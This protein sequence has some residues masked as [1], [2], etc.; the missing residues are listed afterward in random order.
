M[1]RNLNQA[2]ATT[3][4]E[5]IDAGPPLL[6]GVTGGRGDGKTTLL[7]GLL[8]FLRRDGRPADGV[9]AEAEG[10]PGHGLGAERYVLRWPLLGEEAPLCER[11]GKGDPPYRFFDETWDKVGRWAE[12]LTR[13][14]T[15]PEVIVLDEF[16]R[17]EARGEGFVRHWRAI[18]RAQPAVVV[19]ALREGA[20]VEIARHLNQPFDLIV[21]ANEPQ[22]LE[23]LCELCAAARDW[24]LVGRF[25]AASGG[26]E[27]TLGAIL[28]GTKM[29]FRGVVMAA[30]QA[31]T[32]FLAGEKLA[33][34]RR[35]VWVSYLAAALKAL[36]P[37]GNR[38]RPMTAIAMQGTLF[39]SSV[40]LFGWNVAGITMG[41]WLVGAW[42][43]L[44]GYVLQYLLLGDSLLVAYGEVQGWIHRIIGLTIPSLP[45]LVA[46][47]VAVAGTASAVLVTWVRR[48]RRPPALLARALLRA[49]VTEASPVT[50]TWWQRLLREYQ[51][52]A[53]WFPLITVILLLAVSGTPWGRLAG[54]PLRAAGM[55]A[56][57]FV[58]LALLKPGTWTKHLQRRGHWGPAIALARA[59]A[60]MVPSRS[61][62]KDIPPAISETN[63]RE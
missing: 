42:A 54:L 43:A 15:R 26:V 56:F 41:A 14:S 3:A 28:H 61:S 58:A 25:G 7:A 34:P 55:L 62:P 5:A 31:T 17:L 63:P 4:L 30:L 21:P 11:T 9:L 13:Q 46:L 60:P 53:F 6:V 57:L 10:R 39:G 36:S 32:L 23:R 18:L 45:M 47:Y 44:Q 27:M 1:N 48:R 20:A 12:N 22:A 49:R 40:Q 33:R 37:A 50:R 19:V 24:Q 16:G 35:L 29:P 8:D 59:L 51:A 52:R 38:L 2:P